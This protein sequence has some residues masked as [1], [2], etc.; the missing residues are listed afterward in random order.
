MGNRWCL[1]KPTRSVYDRIGFKSTF[2]LKESTKNQNTTTYWGFLF[3]KYWTTF[4]RDKK[5]G[6]NFI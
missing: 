4:L 3:Q 6:I 1:V 5:S 2:A